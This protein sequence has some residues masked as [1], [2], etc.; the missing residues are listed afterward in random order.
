M[1]EKEHSSVSLPHRGDPEVSDWTGIVA[2]WLDRGR[3][4]S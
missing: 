3:P 2:A 4:A 1:D